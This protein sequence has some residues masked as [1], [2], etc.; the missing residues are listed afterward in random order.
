MARK[1]LGF[2]PLIWICP[3]CETKNPGP[4]K[5]CTSCGAPQPDDVEFLRVDEEEFNFIKD[6]ALI[7]MAKAGPDIHCPFCGT[8]NPATAKLCSNCGGELSL[9]G[10]ARQAGGK[11][12]A[13]AEA[14]KPPE[15]AAPAKTKKKMGRGALI[16]ALL[17]GLALIAAC[18][19]GILF[20]TKTDEIRAVVTD[21]E[22]ERSI[23][24]EAYTA[25]TRQ[26]WWDEVPADAEILSCSQEYRYTSD[27]PEPNSTEVCEEEET[28]DT[29]T[30]L[31]EVV[32]YCVYR[33][34]DDYCEYTAW[35][36]VVVNTITE[37]GD[38]LLPYW[39]DF[40]LG[41]DQ[42]EGEREEQYTIVF[43]DGGDTYTYTTSDAA[44]F[45]MAEPGTEWVLEVS[46]FGVRSIKLAN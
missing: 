30:G 22:W 20:L 18:I 24:I 46:N 7:R 36:W 21:V 33:V 35:D 40:N 8:R 5:T 6:E 13:V 42:R 23:A 12:R 37:S 9:G 31:G 32:Q 16:L 44:L 15:P 10:K 2:V 27:Q 1:S 34:Y 45:M 17:G 19:V 28:E 39:P 43:A 14:Q 11:V 41:N 26:D 3:Y 29:G 4:I 38:D 25:V